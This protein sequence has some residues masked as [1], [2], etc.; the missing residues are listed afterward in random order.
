MVE[1]GAPPM[2]REVP[3]PAPGPGEVVVR[4]GG[5]GVCH[6]DLHLLQHVPAGREVPLRLPF[7]LGHENAGW[8]EVL[9]SEVRG[10]DVG[11]PVAVFGHWSCGRCP[12]CAIGHDQYCDAPPGGV[13]VGGGIGLDGGMAELLL[14]P[15][16]RLLLPLGDLDPAKAAPLTDAA[17][18]PYHALKPSVSRLDADSTVVVVGVGGLGHIAI[19]LVRALSPARVVA[20]DRRQAALDAALAHGAALAVEA[21]ADARSAVRDATSGRGAQLV[22][23]FVGTDDSLALS[24]QSA[25]TRADVVVVGIGDGTLPYRPARLPRGVSVRT[26][27]WGTPRELRDVVDL[28]RAG[29]IRVDIQR[30]SLDEAAD[31]YEQLRAGEMRGRAVIVP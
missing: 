1:W 16:A 21:G 2:L 28:A 13:A 14:V 3:E 31:A 29:H 7:T 8:V 11:E 19:Q 10:L 23:D 5:A 12:Q 26:S 15:A 9:G 17:L 24:V 30:F 18:T 22:L 4:V 25:S 27:Y 20:V 6:S